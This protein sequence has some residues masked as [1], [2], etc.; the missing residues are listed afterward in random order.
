MQKGGGIGPMSLD[1]IDSSMEMAVNSART[2]LA[3]IEEAKKNR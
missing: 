3:Q 1:E 2:I